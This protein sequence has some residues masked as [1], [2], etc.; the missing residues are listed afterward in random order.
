MRSR[1]MD[2][3]VAK[4]IARLIPASTMKAVLM[5]R[6][7]YSSAK[8]KHQPRSCERHATVVHANGHSRTNAVP[9]KSGLRTVALIPSRRQALAEATRR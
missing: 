6:I 3:A 2:G 4:T 8:L 7:T 9:E 1:F 5:P